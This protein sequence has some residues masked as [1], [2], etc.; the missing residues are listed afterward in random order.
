MIITVKILFLWSDE[1][2]LNHLWI[3]NS[4]DYLKNFQ[5][6]GVNYSVIIP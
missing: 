4:K 1:M 6:I 3:V 5:N 2:F